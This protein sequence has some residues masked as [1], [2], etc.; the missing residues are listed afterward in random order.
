M[1]PHFVPNGSIEKHEHK[2]KWWPGA[3]RQQAITWTNIVQDPW[4]HFTD[5]H[6]IGCCHV[7]W[8]TKLSVKISH[9]FSYSYYIVICL[10]EIGCYIEY[11]NLVMAHKS[12]SCEW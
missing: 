4:R 5:I 11:N 8:Y 1:C 10:I 2:F 7:L 3:V 6:D 12:G 9:H